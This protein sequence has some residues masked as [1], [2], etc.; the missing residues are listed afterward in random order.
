MFKA[1]RSVGKPSKATVEILIN[2]PTIKQLAPGCLVAEFTEIKAKFDTNV[3]MVKH[4]SKH[5]CES[6]FR[7]LLERIAE[8]PV[9]IVVAYRDT[10]GHTGTEFGKIE[11]PLFTCISSEEFLT[12]IAADAGQYDIFA[13]EN[14]AAWLADTLE[15]CGHAR[16]I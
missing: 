15:K 5:L 3:G 10:C 13:S 14:R 11:P 6:L 8:I 16:R 2:R 9:I 4:A 1:E 7:H 12:Q